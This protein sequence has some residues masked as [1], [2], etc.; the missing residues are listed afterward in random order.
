MNKFNVLTEPAPPA[1]L[2]EANA[3][4]YPDYLRSL[5]ALNP[6]SDGASGKA[7][8]GSLHDSPE[9]TVDVNLSLAR[10]R[11]TSTQFLWC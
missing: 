9:P 11:H 4:V 8:F 3:L 7:L 6:L 1:L 2:M 10:D 5:A